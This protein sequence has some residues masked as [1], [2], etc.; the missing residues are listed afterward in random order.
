VPVVAKKEPTYDDPF[1]PEA[2]GELE[3]LDNMASVRLTAEN[4]A[5][6]N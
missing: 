2:T 3:V 5:V 6:K 1:V 4:E